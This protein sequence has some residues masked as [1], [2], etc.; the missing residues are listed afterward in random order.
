MREFVVLPNP[1]KVRGKLAPWN[2]LPLFPICPSRWTKAGDCLE[3]KT[4]GGSKQALETDRTREQERERCMAAYIT[5]DRVTDEGIMEQCYSPPWSKIESLPAQPR[6]A[7]GQS[8]VSGVKI[9]PYTTG[10]TH[11][12][13]GNIPLNMPEILLKPL[14]SE[15]MLQLSVPIHRNKTFFVTVGDVFH[16]FPAAGRFE[17][18]ISCSWTAFLLSFSLPEVTLKDTHITIETVQIWASSFLQARCI[19]SRHTNQMCQ[20]GAITY[21]CIAAVTVR[22]F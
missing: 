17:W 1:S 15:A 6:E 9:Q 21:E 14:H 2:S 12:N 22:L 18:A 7:P 20:D 13:V 10:N 19:Y 8:L 4:D 11:F 16:G 3:G 5:S